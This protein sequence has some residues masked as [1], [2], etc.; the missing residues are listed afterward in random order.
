M[1]S[2]KY[3]VINILE[4]YFLHFPLCSTKR[5]FW[6]LT[7]SLA[8]RFHVSKYPTLKLFRYGQ[9]MRR[10]FRGQRSAKSLIDFAKSHLASPIKIL[11][12]ADEL[13][14]TDVSLHALSMP[15][16]TNIGFR[17]SIGV[18]SSLQLGRQQGRL[19]EDLWR[20]SPPNFFSKVR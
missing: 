9:M 13:Y 7:A 20:N 16:G 10:E 6:H 18:D 1:N 4:N 8:Q 11:S 5:M 2:S 19:P 3:S 15:I 12:T 14:S 17:I